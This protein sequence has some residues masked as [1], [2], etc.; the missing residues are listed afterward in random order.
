[1]KIRLNPQYAGL[2]SWIRQLEDPA[3]FDRN[4]V[5][6]HEGRNTI[7]RFEAGGETFVIKRYGKPSLINCMIYGTLRGSKAT[8][9][10]LHARKLLRLGIDTPEMVAAIDI[11]RFGLLQTSYFVSREAAG[12]PLRPVTERFAASP[13]ENAPVLEALAHFIFRVHNAGICHED[14]NIGNILYR[15]DEGGGY[16]F[17]LIDTNRMT[18]HRRLSKRRRLNNLRRLSCAAPAYLYMLN[19]YAGLLHSNPNS[20]QYFGVLMRLRF[21]FRQHCKQH[22]KRGIRKIRHEQQ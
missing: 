10:F 4:G 13:S 3:W 6:L 18:F 20:I 16:R 5:P 12:E 14:L 7:K 9:A 21:E 22:V 1:M 19:R 2:K 8:R 11:R 15:R 17:E